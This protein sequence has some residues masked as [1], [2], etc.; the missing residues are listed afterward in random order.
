MRA[1]PL[2][3]LRSAAGEELLEAAMASRPVVAL[4][5]D[6]TLAPLVPRPDDAAMD[7]R[8]AT[9]LPRLAAWVPVA[10][11]SGRGLG[12]LAGRIP[13]DGLVLVGDHGNDWRGLPG[14]ESAGEQRARQ[15]QVCREWAAR[16]AEPLAAL[17][18]G[19]AFE[20]KALSL[21]VHY[22]QVGD[23]PRMRQ[24]LLELFDTLDPRPTIIEGKFVVNLVAPG[25]AT[26]FEAVEQLVAHHNGGTAI[27][28]GDDVTD[29][30]VFER[31]PPHW[32]TVRVW[33]D[34]TSPGGSAT[35]AA[36]AFVQ[37]VDG[38]VALLRRME[39]LA[40]NL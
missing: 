26:K 21:S 9:V 19:L 38:V 10:I 40:Q 7:P 11:V 12:D 32:L 29:E 2:I 16:L 18:P 33:D 37:G 23:P 25:L 31:S 17:G 8:A 34:D 1:S 6:G 22:R 30:R 5:F 3:D 28:V 4:D 27:F 39:A 13:V 36:R 35:S 14:M 15:E 24:R 20:S